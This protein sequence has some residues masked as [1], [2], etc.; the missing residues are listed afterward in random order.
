MQRIDIKP[1][2]VLDE[3][4]KIA[5]Y[6]KSILMAAF[7]CLLVAGACEKEKSGMDPPATS[8][9]ESENGP[10]G[11][12]SGIIEF[13]VRRPFHRVDETVYFIDWGNREA[14]YETIRGAAVADSGPARHQ[15]TMINPSGVFTWQVE[16]RRGSHSPLP[17][18]EPFL[19]FDRLAKRLGRKAAEED[20]HKKGIQMLPSEMVLGFPCHVFRLKGGTF[21][22]HRGLVLRSRIRLPNFETFREAVRF[23]PEAAINP[24]R[25]KF[26]PGVDPESF[27]GLRDLLREAEGEDPRRTRS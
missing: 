23:V 26:P 7:L 22:I 20:L 1:S 13:R 3:T 2:W 27:P 24:E 15:I 18:Q 6:R 19:N 17:P 10:Y 11:Y 14:R 9:R 12:I 16:A 21:W 4:V 5:I 8:I 25:L